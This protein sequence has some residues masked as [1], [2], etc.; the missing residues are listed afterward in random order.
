MK[1]T[2][3]KSRATGSRIAGEIFG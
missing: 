2:V 1:S 3:G